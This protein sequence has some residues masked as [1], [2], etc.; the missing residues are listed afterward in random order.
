MSEKII[1]QSNRNGNWNIFIYKVQEDSLEQITYGIA[2]EQNPIWTKDGNSIVFDSDLTGS[3]KLYKMDLL[4][5]NTELLFDR[6]IQAKEACFANS[7]KLVYFS[8]F[9]PLERRW[10]IYSYEF[11]YQNLNKLT[12]LNG[13]SHSPAVSPDE[14]HVVFTHSN[15]QYPFDQLQLMNWYGNDKQLF[16]EFSGID[17]SWSSSGLKVY[18]ISDNVRS[19]YNIL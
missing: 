17:P 14:D 1:F 9:D 19:K 16:T 6:N 11:Q 4:N 8:G 18:F 15:R 10:E 13:K 3:L 7:G 5:K 12:K 2:N